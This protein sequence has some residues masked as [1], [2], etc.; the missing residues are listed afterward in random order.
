MPIIPP[1]HAPAVSSQDS[2]AAVLRRNGNALLLAAADADDHGSGLIGIPPSAAR[3]IGEILIAV[4]DELDQV[5]QAE[6]KPVTRYLN[7][8]EVKQ[9]NKAIGHHWFDADNARQHWIETRLIAGLYWVES[10]WNYEATGR[11]YRAVAVAP[12][13]AVSYLHGAEAFPTRDDARAV[14]DAIIEG[15][16]DE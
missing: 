1:T 6:R 2:A 8:R 9:A 14:I 12:D 5:E 15:R 13:G 10:S 11:E 16:A 4:A 3:R 7:F